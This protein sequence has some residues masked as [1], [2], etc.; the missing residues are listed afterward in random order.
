[1]LLVSGA[2][3]RLARHTLSPTQ[4]ERQLAI[5]EA[6][7]EIA[8]EQATR[9][10]NFALN[11]PNMPKGNE[12][13]KDLTHLPSG[14]PVL[15]YRQKSK[16]WEGS[17]KFISMKGETVVVQLQRGRRIFRSNCIKPWVKSELSNT[18]DPTP[19]KK[20]KENNVMKVNEEEDVDLGDEPKIITVRKRSIEERAF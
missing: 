1:M 18:T 11:H 9:K 8:R 12:T 20:E 6:K 10:I 17:V 5:E 14:T 4:M 16:Y 13:S 3:L 2:L 15:V 19:T 7:K